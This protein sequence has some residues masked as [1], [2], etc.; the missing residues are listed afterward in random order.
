M[1]FK[2]EDFTKEN[3]NLVFGVINFFMEKNNSLDLKVWNKDNGFYSDEDSAN[4]TT[5]IQDNAVD[6][7]HLKKDNDDVITIIFKDNLFTLNIEE[8]QKKEL[9]MS[10]GIVLTEVK[11]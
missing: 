3:S 4:L 5:L 6:E 9:E 11:E 2:I 8:D 10:L 7:I 1:K